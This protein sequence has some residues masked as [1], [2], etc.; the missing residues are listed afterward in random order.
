MPMKKVT[1]NGFDVTYLPY[2]VQ[3]MIGETIVEKSARMLEDEFSDDW[4]VD[5]VTHHCGKKMT[6]SV[7]DEDGDEHVVQVAVKLIKK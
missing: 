5:P 4:K 2:A 1:S 7:F 3:D 6:F